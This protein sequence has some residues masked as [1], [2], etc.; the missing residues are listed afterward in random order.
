VLRVIRRPGG[1]LPTRL[2]GGDVR[3]E[4]QFVV[5]SVG[6]QGVTELDYPRLVIDHVLWEF[7]SHE[8]PEIMGPGPADVGQVLVGHISQDMVRDETVGLRGLPLP[9]ILP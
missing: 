7:A 5:L 9:F 4:R 6:V 3:Y 8:L 1:P 2:P